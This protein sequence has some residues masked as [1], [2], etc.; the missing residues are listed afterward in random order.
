M[1]PRCMYSITQFWT[2]ITVLILLIFF[3]RCKILITKKIQ[4]GIAKIEKK[5]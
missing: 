4:A 1:N 3:E 5:N 2:H